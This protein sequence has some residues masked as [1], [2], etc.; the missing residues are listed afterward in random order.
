VEVIGLNH[1]KGRRYLLWLERKK[2]KSWEMGEPTGG[3][4]GIRN[5]EGEGKKRNAA[6][7]L[8]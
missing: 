3:L 6:G 1:E 4:W 7:T 8:K 2:E 5:K